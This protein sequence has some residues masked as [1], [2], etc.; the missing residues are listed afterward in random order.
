MHNKPM[1]QILLSFNRIAGLV[2]LLF[3]PMFADTFGNP[4]E[5]DPYSSIDS[6]NIISGEKVTIPYEIQLQSF[7]PMYGAPSA[8]LSEFVP[9]ECDLRSLLVPQP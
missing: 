9:V 1:P 6:P 3:T 5:V 7:G 8:P 2:A 4:I